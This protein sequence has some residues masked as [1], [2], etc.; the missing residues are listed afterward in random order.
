MTDTSPECHICS[1]SIDVAKSKLQLKPESCSH[2]MCDGCIEDLILTDPNDEENPNYPCP[3]CA[4]SETCGTAEPTEVRND[5][6]GSDSNGGISDLTL[7]VA[8]KVNINGSET[9]VN[10]D[11]KGVKLCSDQCIFCQE[12][13]STQ[14]GEQQHD[15]SED[16]IHTHPAYAALN[17]Q[18]VSNLQLSASGDFCG[19]GHFKAHVKQCLLCQNEPSLVMDKQHDSYSTLTF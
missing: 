15:S 10:S 3:F 9:E 2:F 19:N 4:K 11:K 1:E 18:K 7:I 14:S 12:V 6:A 16:S 8:D 17:N 5:T 13:S